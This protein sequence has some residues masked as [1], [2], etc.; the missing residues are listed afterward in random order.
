[1]LAM[2]LFHSESAIG[3]ETRNTMNSFDGCDKKRTATNALRY[4][5]ALA[6][7]L[8]SLGAALGQSASAKAGAG[9]ADSSGLGF[10]IETEMLTYSALESNSEAIACDVAAYLNK[11]SANFSSPPAGSVCNVNAG[12][13]EATVVILPF[14]RN[15][16]SDFEI[17]RSDIVTMS[18]LED[19]AKATYQCPKTAASRTS[20]APTMLASI[21][22]YGALAETALSMMSKDQSSAP[23]VGTIQDQAFMDGVARQ[24]RTLKVR[25]MMPA[26][27]T[28]YGLVALD[29]SHSP[30]MTNL[31]KLI[32]ARA[33]LADLG[34][35]DANKDKTG[36]DQLSKDIDGFFAS[37]TE[38]VQ[39]SPAAAQGAK[40]AAATTAPASTSTPASASTPGSSASIP[41]EPARSHLAAALAADSIEQK[42]GVDMNTGTLANRNDWPHILLVKAL[43]SGGSVTR[44]TSLL[45]TT[46]S[47][48]GGSVGTYSLFRL[49][50]ELECSGN[51]FDFSGSVPSKGFEAT[52]RNSKVD[53][54]K[55]MIFTRGSCSPQ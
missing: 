46:Q 45:K 24:L 23:V 39:P 51:V 28:S 13:N 9:S 4:S 43:E 34:A 3:I 16:F 17:W 14:D 11:T 55:Q 15:E 35:S 1:M 20:T 18:Q 25:V 19:R 50:G 54:S 53:P 47:Y 38:T 6:F 5:V 30:F 49:D 8:V 26:D 32:E 33:C 42:F 7:G 21:S 10:S 37:L 31:N 29:Q 22:P 41:P 27:Y 48:S 36:V 12:S 44:N 2:G 40:T 52:Y